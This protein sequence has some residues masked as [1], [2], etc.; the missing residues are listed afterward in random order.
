MDEYLSAEDILNADDF[1]YKEVI[2]KQWAGTS[3][4]KLRLKSMSA[5]AV[6]KFNKDNQAAGD[7]QEKRDAVL[8]RAIINSA[9][10]KDGNMLFSEEHQ[11]VLM[12]KSIKPLLQVQDEFMELNGMGDT[13]AKAAAA[14]AA[15]ELAAK[16]ASGEAP[17]GASPTA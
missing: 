15:Q 17:I 6:L 7:D 9:C 13:A 2:V 16:N 5:A 11:A 1:E 10:D 12:A 14:Q 4:K 8:A 3:N